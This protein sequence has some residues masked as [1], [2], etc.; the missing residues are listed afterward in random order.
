MGIPATH[1]CTV[2]PIS[3]TVGAVR[4]VAAVAIPHPVGNPEL[5]SDKEHEIRMGIIKKALSLLQT[6]Y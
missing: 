4:I 5:Q 3:K 6:R 2:T 1:I